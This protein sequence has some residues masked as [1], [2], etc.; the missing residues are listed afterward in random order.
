[1]ANSH[2]EK[3]IYSARNYS[4]LPFDEPRSNVP[5]Q[6]H[7][8]LK[9]C[10]AGKIAVEFTLARMLKHPDRHDA[11]RGTALM[12]VI[13]KL[14]LKMLASLILFC[15]VAGIVVLIFGEDDAGYRN[16]G[17]RLIRRVGKAASSTANIKNM[18]PRLQTQLGPHPRQLVDLRVSNWLAG[19]MEVTTEIL[20]QWVKELIK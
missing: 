17:L 4:A 1:M 10:S 11:V 20:T 19:I 13:A 8:A 5:P 2:P 7:L 6:R 12:A 18:M 3:Y 14:K 9:S 16:I 15:L